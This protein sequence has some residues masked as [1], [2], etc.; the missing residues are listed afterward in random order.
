MTLNLVCTAIL[1]LMYFALSLN[2]SLK[3]ISRKESPN[4]EV[5]LTK[6][7][8]AHGNAS[9]YIPLFVVLFFYYRES[10]SWILAALVIVSTLGRIVHAIG[11]LTAETATGPN[12]GKFIGAVATYT[13]LLGFGLVVLVDAFTDYP[14]A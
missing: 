4:R 12:P 5:Q 10:T 2:V 6:A 14:M 1:V 3:R 8:R 11:M 9:E 13:G 7:I